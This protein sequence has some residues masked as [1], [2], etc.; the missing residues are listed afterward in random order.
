MAWKTIFGH[1]MSLD[2]RFEESMEHLKTLLD[3]MANNLIGIALSKSAVAINYCLQG[4]T[5]WRYR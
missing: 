4:K 5:I 1:R 2:Y 3:L